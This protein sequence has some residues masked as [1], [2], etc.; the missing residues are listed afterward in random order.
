MAVP[1][2]ATPSPPMRTVQALAGTFSHCTAPPHHPVKTTSTVGAGRAGC[3]RQA[4]VAQCGRA[5]SSGGR[6]C[7]GHGQQ[8]LVRVLYQKEL[9]SRPATDPR[10]AANRTSAEGRHFI[11]PPDLLELNPGSVSRAQTTSSGTPEP[12][13]TVRH[14]HPHLTVNPGTIRA[15]HDGKKEGSPLTPKPRC[16]AETLRNAL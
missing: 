4:R 13:E 14:P 1:L 5:P 7:I 6:N 3:V 2:H 15:L 10:V 11:E 9:L 16:N 8:G 12:Q